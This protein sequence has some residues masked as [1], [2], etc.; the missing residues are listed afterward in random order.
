[1]PPRPT[2]RPHGP[3]DDPRGYVRSTSLNNRDNRTILRAARAI[4]LAARYLERGRPADV[5]RVVT[6]GAQDAR[7]EVRPCYICHK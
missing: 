5:L 2:F 6:L 7:H 4:E 3:R 1:M